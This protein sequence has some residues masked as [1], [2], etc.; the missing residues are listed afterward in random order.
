M[1]PM[2]EAALAYAR[3]GYPIF[4]LA[5]KQPIE[6]PGTANVDGLV[7]PQGQSGFHQ[8]TTDEGKLTRWWAAY[9]DA[10]LGTPT[11]HHTDAVT[12]QRNA[13]P[14]DV[15]DIDLDS[16]GIASIKALIKANAPLPETPY[17][18]TGSGGHHYCF[19]SDGSI[20]NS[21]GGI[22]PGIDVRGTG[23]YIVVGPSIHPKTQEAYEW[24]V[25]LFGDDARALASWPAWLLSII[26]DVSR[27][28]SQAA[29]GQRIP[30]GM[31]EATLMRIAGAMRRQGSTESEILAAMRVI[32]QERCDPPVKP[33]DLSR[34]AAS[35]SSYEPGNTLIDFA[36]DDAGNAERLVTRYGDVMRHVADA[37]SDGWYCYDGRT[38]VDTTSKVVQHQIETA[39]AYQDAAQ[40]LPGAEDG[41]DPDT[42]AFRKAHVVN[43]K[44]CG[45]ERTMKAVRIIAGSFP[46]VEV[47]RSELDPDPWAF[48][49]ANGIID[50]KTGEMRPHHPAELITRISPA[51][52]DPGATSQLWNDF[53]KWLTAD[54]QSLADF[55][56]MAVG[57]SLTADVREE[58]LFFIHGR[59]ASG[60]TTF[61]EA[62]KSILGDYAMTSDFSTFLKGH[63]VGGPRSD[64]AR[65]SG[66][67][68][69][70][71]VEVDQGKAL[72]EGLVKQMTGGDTVT[73]R[74]LYGAE[75]EYATTHK[76]WLVANDAPKVNSEDDGLWRRILRIPCDNVVPV[77]QRDS[78]I[79]ARLKNVQETGPAILAWAVAGALRW[80]DAGRLIIPDSIKAAT[81][82][83]REAQDPIT[84][85]LAEVC[86]AAPEEKTLFGD[87]WSAYLAYCKQYRRQPM[88]RNKFGDRLDAKGFVRQRTG[89][90]RYIKG[91][92]LT[93]SDLD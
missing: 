17:Q 21:A 83:Y 71:S 53:L 47:K 33:A 85:F 86:E 65:L 67:R 6:Q 22:A 50:L 68:F 63:N 40:A 66:A 5:G 69:V 78:T 49:C 72:A 64:I 84:D 32:S 35:A 4:P 34:M 92:R 28:R 51:T 13:S 79:K 24:A 57:Y 73:A 60:K 25:P 93:A 58:K 54:R 55:L 91:L 89:G 39:R 29:P 62:V 36:I 9:P 10:N 2:L 41:D 56:Q 81:D 74:F 88:G 20:R 42:R 7:I 52:Y 46:E 87:L 3:A 8:A 37:R 59:A 14:F 12:G 15:L 38:W 1:T 30:V 76:L 75:F 82:E 43:A 23:G 70:S 77:D 61:I 48:A 16:G 27:K 19:A 45:Q 90:G 26:R 44:A 31:Q 18:I 11:G 80:Q